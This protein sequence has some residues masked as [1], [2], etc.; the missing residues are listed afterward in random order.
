MRFALSGVGPAV[1][2]DNEPFLPKSLH[3]RLAGK[4]LGNGLVKAAYFGMRY[5]MKARYQA[6]FFERWYN[7]GSICESCMAQQPFKNSDP[8][9]NYKDFRETAVHRMT[10]IS[11]ET[12][13]R[14][15]TI[16]SPWL[17]VE[18]WTLG[19]AFRDPMHCMYLGICASVRKR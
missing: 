19:T 6:N 14:T 16:P 9:M 17:A 11:H 3:A 15:A 7:C 18:G 13:C 4:T 5:D 2:F 12:Y 1:G 10:V 8:A